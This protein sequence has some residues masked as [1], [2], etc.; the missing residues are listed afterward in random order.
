MVIEKNVDEK[1]IEAQ[2]M[3]DFVELKKE[4]IR[5]MVNMH[6]NDKL[7]D[8]EHQKFYKYLTLQLKENTSKNNLDTR[9]GSIYRLVQK[10]YNNY[11]ALN[12]IINKLD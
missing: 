4:I 10:Q 2:N 9:I 12:E 3:M 8:E 7:T 6:A 5:V 1:I 11:I